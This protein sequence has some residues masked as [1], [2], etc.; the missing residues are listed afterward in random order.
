MT[1]IYPLGHPPV[2]PAAGFPVL[3]KW[4]RN[5]WEM[6]PQR[7]QALL[8]TTMHTVPCSRQKLA[9]FCCALAF[10]ERVVAATEGLCGGWG[11]ALAA[12][13]HEIEDFPRVSLWSLLLLL[14][15]LPR[16]LV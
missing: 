7:S 11:K 3:I 12:D 4:V 10:C 15:F 5:L 1:H 14:L 2:K 16:L 9:F 6:L 8:G 13:K